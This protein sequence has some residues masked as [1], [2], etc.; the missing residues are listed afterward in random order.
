MAFSLMQYNTTR[1]VLAEAWLNHS[2]ARHVIEPIQFRLA[3]WKRERSDANEA[4]VLAKID[5]F[6]EWIETTNADRPLLWNAMALLCE[7]LDI[8]Q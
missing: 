4:E 5:D 3:E 7:L 2:E 8:K 6:Q 1:A